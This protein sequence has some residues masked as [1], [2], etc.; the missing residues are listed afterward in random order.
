MGIL[1][2]GDAG[3]FSGLFNVNTAIYLKK[4]GVLVVFETGESPFHVPK[5]NNEQ[6]DPITHSPAIH[7]ELIRICLVP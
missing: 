4:R 3:V 1:K 2:N 7:L 6:L 5:L